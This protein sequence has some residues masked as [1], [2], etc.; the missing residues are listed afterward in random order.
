M[1]QNTKHIGISG[2]GF[3]GKDTLC[4]ALI[5]TF[6]DFF[7][8]KSVRRSIAGDKVRNDL[9]SLVS[10]KFGIDIQTPTNEQKTLLRPFMVSY[11]RIQRELTDG[12]YF[13][14]KFEP[15]G[16]IDIIPDI[17]YAE[18]E[19]DEL[20][21]IKEEKKGFLIYME[22]DGILPANIYEEENNKLIKEKADYF[23]DWPNFSENELKIEPLRYAKVIIDEWFKYISSSV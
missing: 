16:F 11:G 14:D 6:G 15:S 7:K 13:I 9:E 10:E 4:T 19:K 21:W 23:L 5:Q 8:L 18:Y 1:E 2:A 12:R 22:R 17:R 3:V 20:Y